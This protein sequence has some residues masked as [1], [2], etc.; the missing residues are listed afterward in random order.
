IETVEFVFSDFAPDAGLPNGRT[1]FGM[2]AP[3]TAVG[4]AAGLTGAAAPA[5]SGGAGG[6]GGFPGGG[7]P[8]GGLF[9]GQR[10]PGQEGAPDD[11]RM[12]SALGSIGVNGFI[13]Q[14]ITANPLEY[15]VEQYRARREQ[16]AAWLDTT[17]PDLSAFRER[18]GKMIVAVG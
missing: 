13:M 1:T 5:D 17:N 8:G 14:D 7:F 4:N 9:S 15:D 3:T 6:R 2:W 11:A 10:Y 16:I 18:G 12:F